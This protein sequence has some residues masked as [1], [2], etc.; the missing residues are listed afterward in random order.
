MRLECFIWKRKA[1][2]NGLCVIKLPFV[3]HKSKKREK[4]VVAIH[5]IPFKVHLKAEC[6]EKKPSKFVNSN[7]IILSQQYNFASK[8]I[9]EI[10]FLI[11][12]FL[13]TYSKN[14][15]CQTHSPRV[16]ISLTSA[17][18]REHKEMY[19]QPRQ[20]EKNE[21]QVTVGAADAGLPRNNVLFGAFWVWVQSLL[22][23]LGKSWN[24]LCLKSHR[25]SFFKIAHSW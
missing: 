24:C 1:E 12:F 5:F 14:I 21:S 3:V 17:K 7:V 25:S 19:L 9:T 11:Y 20:W 6:M 15:V 23:L 8:F 22:H 13:K 18:N 2:K 16:I 4:K 10:C